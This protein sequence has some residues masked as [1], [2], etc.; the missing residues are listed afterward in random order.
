MDF[1]LFSVSSREF[2]HFASLAVAFSAHQ[3]HITIA[4][5]EFWMNGAESETPANTRR[6][7]KELNIS[8]FVWTGIKMKISVGQLHYAMQFICYLIFWYRKKPDNANT[9]RGMF[10]RINIC[11]CYKKPGFLSI[12]LNYD[13]FSR[14]LSLIA[15]NHPVTSFVNY[16]QLD[17][18]GIS[19]TFRLTLF[20]VDALVNTISLL[21]FHAALL[22]K[23]LQLAAYKFRIHFQY[24]YE[25]P[26]MFVH[27]NWQ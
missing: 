13:Q 26:Q 21:K 20:I 11:Q 12:Q 1:S 14:Y 5:V 9:A 22:T 23:T 4:L 15:P 7:E 27:K 16:G 24:C 17:D 25:F 19:E 18:F 2:F 3:M 8:G 10:T 6:M